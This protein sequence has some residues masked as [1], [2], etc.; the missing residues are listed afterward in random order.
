MREHCCDGK[1]RSVLE[2]RKE[3]G[4]REIEIDR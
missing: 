4:V 1:W 2:Q 3:T